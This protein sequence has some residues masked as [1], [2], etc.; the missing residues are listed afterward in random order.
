MALRAEVPAARPDRSPA[1]VAQRR[2]I[3]DQAR[4]ANAR[5]GYVYDAELEAINDAYVVG[6]L[7]SEECSAAVDALTADQVAAFKAAEAA[8]VQAERR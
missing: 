8:K 5:Q 4:A 2:S 1:D 6:D 3:T 7:M